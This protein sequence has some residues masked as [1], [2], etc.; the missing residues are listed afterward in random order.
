MKIFFCRICFVLGLFFSAHL[1]A[2]DFPIKLYKVDLNTHD[3]A[4]ILR[5]AKAYASYCLVCHSLKYMDRDPFAKAAGITANRMPDASK[6]WWF[7]S[8]PPDLTLIARIH[9]VNWL[10]TYL[11]VFYQDPSRPSG[12]NNLLADNINMPN[13][14]AG[15]QGP[16]QLLVD[17]TVLFHTAEVPFTR[18]L[19]YY[20]VLNLIRQGALPP[21]KFDQ[22]TLDLVNFLVYASEPKK[23]ARERL[24]VWVLI[25][26]GILALLT[27]LLKQ[28]YW[29]NRK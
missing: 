12:S 23:Y 18:K 6:N 2:E 11:H 25:G 9:G 16:Q 1:H 8:A 21:D 4:S 10:Y 20:T 29:R 24:G 28:A 22:L 7:G 14:F 19:P 13:P 17:K 26:L 15:I 3:P 5:G 27:Y